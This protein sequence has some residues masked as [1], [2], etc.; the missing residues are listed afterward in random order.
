[1]AGVAAI[2]TYV[3]Q[4]FW[5]QGWESQASKVRIRWA[6]CLEVGIGELNQWST[7]IFNEKSLSMKHFKTHC[8]LTYSLVNWRT[9]C[10]TGIFCVLYILNDI[11]L[12]K[13]PRE[14]EIIIFTCRHGSC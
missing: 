3:S 10:C 4:S 6:T 8:E 2:V 11:V 9:F 14:N 13:G 12:Y 5:C 7:G 1:M